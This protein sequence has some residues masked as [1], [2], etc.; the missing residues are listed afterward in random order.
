MLP[1]NVCCCEAVLPPSM[2]LQT[3]MY[4]LTWTSR[5]WRDV[6]DGFLSRLVSVVVANWTGVFDA[7]FTDRGRS[8]K[9]PKR[10]TG[11]ALSPCVFVEQP[12]SAETVTAAKIR[13]KGRENFFIVRSSAN[14]P[15]RD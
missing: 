5:N 3:T 2:R 15:R 11:E 13:R 6:A 9:L 4:W 12:G 10:N 1:P 7:T 14:D 8:V